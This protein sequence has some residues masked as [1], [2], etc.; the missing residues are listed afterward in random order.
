M[1]GRKKAKPEPSRSR[2]GITDTFEL[3]RYEAFF[4]TYKQALFVLK[5]YGKGADR[6]RAVHPFDLIGPEHSENRG[7]YIHA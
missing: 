1:E 3:A 5:H 6:I 2:L 4:V 7:L